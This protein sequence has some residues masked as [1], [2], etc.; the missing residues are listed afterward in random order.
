MAQKYQEGQVLQFDVIPFAPKS[1]IQ[2]SQRQKTTGDFAE[3]QGA[4]VILLERQEEHKHW[5]LRFQKDTHIKVAA[6]HYG[7]L[8]ILLNEG[9]GR[10]NGHLTH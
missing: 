6:I 9:S 2:R 1:Y 3:H 5:H 4:Q 7:Q 10:L 8:K